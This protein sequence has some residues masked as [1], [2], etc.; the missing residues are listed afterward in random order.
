MKAENRSVF[1]KSLL[2][3]MSAAAIFAGSAMPVFAETESNTTS[4]DN[5]SFKKQYTYSIPAS[6]DA[7]SYKSPEEKFTFYSTQNDNNV[8]DVATLQYVS[9]SSYNTSDS[10]LAA[11]PT[12][13]NI[14]NTIGIGSAVYLE[15]GARLALEN[16]AFSD[17]D[18]NVSISLNDSS[19]PIPGVYYYWFK[20]RDNGT[21][22]VKYDQN[23]YWIAVQVAYDTTTAGTKVSSIHLLKDDNGEPDI[24]TTKDGTDT[25]YSYKQE[26]VINTY[27]AGKLEVTKAVVGNLGDTTKEFAVKVTFGSNKPVKSTINVVV[28]NDPRSTSQG[29]KISGSQLIKSDSSE[30]A[31]TN[32]AASDASSSQATNKFMY[33]NTFTYYVKDKTQ[34]TFQNIPVGVYVN[35]Q[36]D[37]YPEYQTTYQLDGKNAE[38]SVGFFDIAGN[39]VYKLNITNTNDTTL[40]TGVFTSNLPYFII[41]I[42]AAGGLVIFLMSRKHHV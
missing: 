5:Y 35:V 8:E 19:Y 36:E 15:G 17:S 13:K 41:L 40:P 1:K 11:A 22:G 26:G 14:P 4:T 32:D 24:S 18:P 21:A 30:S 6:E 16:N 2:G 20:E 28:A 12:D 37:K 29:G 7:T 3:I 42:A 10:K 9:D 27:A 31:T 23:K 34:I 33:Q 39:N 38:D 25:K